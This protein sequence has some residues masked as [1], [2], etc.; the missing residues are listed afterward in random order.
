MTSTRVL[1]IVTALL[2]TVTGVALLTSPSVPASLLVGASL[3]TPSVFAVARVTGAAMLSL[4]TACWLARR[5]G[6][7]L[8]GRSMVTAMLV[9]NV[10][11]V[12]V[13][14][15]AS[16]ALE[17]TAVLLWP[18]VGGHTALAAWCIARLRPF[19]LSARS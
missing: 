5:D 17:V 14:V 8:A 6:E 1:L 4:G 10:A 16:L 15:H 2:E 9:Y 13:L 11:V 12:A 18:A 19:R 7:S 3:D